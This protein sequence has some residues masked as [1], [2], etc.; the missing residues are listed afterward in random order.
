[1]VMKEAINTDC[2]AYYIPVVRWLPKMIFNRMVHSDE[3]I[4]LQ[5]LL[6]YE[7]FDTTTS[8]LDQ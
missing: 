1:M 3:K 8:T 6:Y 4:T 2:G 7:Y 5:I